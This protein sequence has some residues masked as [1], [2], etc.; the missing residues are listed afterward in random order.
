MLLGKTKAF[1]A[2]G[3]G[4]EPDAASLFGD[5]FESNAENGPIGSEGQAVWP[6][7]D[8]HGIFG[9]QILE[10]ERFEI[11]EAGDAIEIHMINAGASLIL[12]NQSERGA[13]DIFFPRGTEPADDPFRQRRLPY[14]ELAGKENQNRRLET[15]ADFAA[16]L[17]GFVGRM[18]DDFAASHG[19]TRNK[20][21]GRHEESHK[22]GRRP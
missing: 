17:D 11:V 2:G 10:A 22:S 7:D 18:C 5:V 6:F 12:V 20:T 3:Y 19:R 1:L 9:K 21:A 14:P 15:R 16:A 4:F 8:D 13:G